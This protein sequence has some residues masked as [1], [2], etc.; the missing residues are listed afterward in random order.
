MREG[1]VHDSRYY[2]AAVCMQQYVS[3]IQISATAW[4][5]SMESRLSA[6]SSPQIEV[7]RNIVECEL[8]PQMCI[9]TCTPQSAQNDAIGGGKKLIAWKDFCED[10]DSQDLNDVTPE[11]DAINRAGSGWIG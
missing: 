1:A 3:N 7:H 5:I 8:L 2:S 6:I 11:L 10:V 9:F 4:A